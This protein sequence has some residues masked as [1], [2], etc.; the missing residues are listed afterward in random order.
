MLYTINTANYFC[1]LRITFL[2]LSLK[3]CAEQ[4]TWHRCNLFRENQFEHY[5]VFM[6]EASFKMQQIV[7]ISRR[8]P[9]FHVNISFLFFSLKKTP[10]FLL[11][12]L[13]PNFLTRPVV[14]MGLTKKYDVMMPP[15]ERCR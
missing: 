12:S 11:Y 14:F 1:Q 6:M 3:R 5:R 4:S 8:S 7:L 9:A 13:S 2:C 10:C 15:R